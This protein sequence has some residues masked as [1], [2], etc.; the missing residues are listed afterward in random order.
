[1]VATVTSPLVSMLQRRGVPRAAG[2]ARV[3][4]GLLVL[5]AGF[6]VM[7]VGG[8]SSQASDLSPKG[9]RSRRT[10]TPAPG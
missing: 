8:I 4:L 5:G 1:V 9:A 10:A 7:L 3:F 6:V 2:A